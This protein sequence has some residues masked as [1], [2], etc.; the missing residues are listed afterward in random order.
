CMGARGIWGKSTMHEE[1]AGIPMIMAGPDVPE[2]KVCTSPVNLVDVFPTVLANSGLPV[3]EEDRQLPGRSLID[4]AQADTDSERISF[5]EYHGAGSISAAFMI[6][7]GRFKYVHYT[8]FDPELF[9]LETDPEEQVNLAADKKYSATVSMF[10]DILHSIL[11]PQGVDA[12]A[13]NDQA[14]LVQKHGGIEAILK[15]GGLSGTPVPGGS[16]TRVK[17]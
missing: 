14:Q 4:I 12:N 13:K 3:P 1:S 6:R 16:S 2:G 17:D 5:S 11:D 7:R 9:D 10:S 15:L 8:N